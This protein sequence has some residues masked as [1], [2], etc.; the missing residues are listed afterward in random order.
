MVDLESGG[1]AGEEVVLGGE[2]AAAIGEEGEGGS[3][4][5]CAAYETHPGNHAHPANFT[6]DGGEQNQNE[7]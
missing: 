7:S 4:G 6:F 5:E 1:D 2:V 3:A